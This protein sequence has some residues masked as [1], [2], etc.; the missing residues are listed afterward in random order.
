MYLD[1]KIILLDN[2]ND[3]EIKDFTKKA[4]GTIKVFE[5]KNKFLK[6]TKSQD[7]FS[8]IRQELGKLV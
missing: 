2:L 3:F 7:I 5:V 1:E 8:F 4:G 6:S